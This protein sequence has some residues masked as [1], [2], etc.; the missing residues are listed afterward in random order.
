MTESEI[1]AGTRAVRNL[2][3]QFAGWYAGLVSDT[4]CR[5]IAIAVLKAAEAVRK[6]KS[7]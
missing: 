2:V 4:H 3:D 5:E 7:K 1:V 6:R